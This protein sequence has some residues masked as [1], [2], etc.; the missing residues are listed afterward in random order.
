MS[1]LL[2]LVA[3]L[4]ESAQALI[5]EGLDIGY[6]EGQAEI[7]T[8]DLS[9]P[10][11]AIKL[12]EAGKNRAIV[13]VV[14][15]EGAYERGQKIEKDLY[16]TP[17]FHHYEDDRSLVLY[18]NEVHGADLEVPEE[19]PV[20]VT[21]SYSDT[22]E[23]SAESLNSF[24]ENSA[25]SLDSVGEGYRNTGALK[26]ENAEL[27][28]IISDLTRQLNE[29]YVEPE[30]INNDAELRAV[31][32]HN[33]KLESI[34]EQQKTHS[35][36]LAESLRASAV[37][38][39]ALKK[40]LIEKDS[41]ISIQSTKIITLE[42]NAENSKR[43][44]SQLES[45]EEQLRFYKDSA[46]SAGNTIRT[47][48]ET[49]TGLS[50]TISNLRNQAVASEGEEEKLR[51]LNKKIT[52]LTSEMEFVQLELDKAKAVIAKFKVHEEKLTKSFETE[53]KE[54]LDSLTIAY[55]G[56]LLI[57]ENLI[58]HYITQINEA[59][60]KVQTDLSTGQIESVA[61]FES[62]IFYGIS[63]SAMPKSLPPM[64]PISNDKYKN[65][66][67]VFSATRSSTDDTMRSIL[68]YTNSIASSWSGG[69][70]VLDISNETVTDYIFGG[71]VTSQG[72]RW[73]EGGVEVDKIVS[74]PSIGN[75]PSGQVR[76]LSLGGSSFVNDAYLLDIDW[77][78]RLRE[79]ENSGYKIVIYAGCL[80]DMVG[81]VFYRT[82]AD[83]GQTRVYSKG[84][85]VSMRSAYYNLSAMPFYD[86]VKL[87]IFDLIHSKTSQHVI[88]SLKDANF[89]PV[90]D[91]VVKRKE[92]NA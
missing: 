28:G 25:D 54:A 53:K 5:Q 80:S 62:S 4:P 14:F 71:P 70:L 68:N 43:I 41:K 1:S 7:E 18:L 31:K 59:P 6:G 50:S 84:N 22:D 64:L 8:L 58:K 75:S 65:I 36:S 89:E 24:N 77:S 11:A 76:F 23:E 3:G 69:V 51:A 88:Q 10:R 19:A 26:A 74:T 38:L 21:L 60:A 39:E 17:K 81:R 37:E 20:S 30:V 47:L 63:K 79:L 12:R 16:G 92:N 90:I 91:S 49:N 67:F 72:V 73:A 78:T 15:G 61:Q 83:K 46:Q 66:T 85:L 2:A 55:D 44:T 13:T 27:H 9:V 86:S 82:F 56:E 87:H 48:T 42:T 32:N 34:N 33:E 40:N 57:K 29:A 45:T 35:R 52:D